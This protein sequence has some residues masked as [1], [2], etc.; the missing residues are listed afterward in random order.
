L[1]LEFAQKSEAIIALFGFKDLKSFVKNQALLMLMGKI[2]KYVAENNHFE[3]KYAMSFQL[4]QDKIKS[5]KNE[6]VFEEDDYLAW[7]FAKEAAD[8]LIRQKQELENA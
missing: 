4:F 3:A 5:L 7:R 8:R 1:G 2:E 6:E